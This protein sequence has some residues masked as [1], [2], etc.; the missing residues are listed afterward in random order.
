MNK[1][2]VYAIVRT[3]FRAT[4]CWPNCNIKKVE[5]LKYE[6]HH[7]FNVIVKISQV[8]RSDRDVEYLVFQQ[9]LDDIIKV[10][11]KKLSI[12]RSCEDM[13]EWLYEKISKDYYDR[14]IEVEVNEDGYFGALITPDDSNIVR[15][16]K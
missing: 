13:A 7:E 11:L 6:H 4:H 5:F 15:K 3:K 9:Y 2:N 8:H 14:R 10:M 16:L 1:L 12:K